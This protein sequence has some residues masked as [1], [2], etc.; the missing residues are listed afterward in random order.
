MNKQTVHEE[1]LSSLATLLQ[2]DL[3]NLID[4]EKE[5]AR[6]EINGKIRELKQDAILIA[7]GTI[8]AA[9][10]LICLGAAGILGLSVVL[11]PWL[12]ALIVAG[13][14]GVLALVLFVAFQ[15]RIR[16]LDPVPHTTVANVKR[17]VRAIQEAVR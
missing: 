6:Q 9:M 7:G 10:F 15:S 14:F 2:R 1:P 4:A 11:A 16:R 3:V 5:L 17:D 8:G 12:A 13:S